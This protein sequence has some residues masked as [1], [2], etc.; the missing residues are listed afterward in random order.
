MV[1]GVKTGGRKGF[2]YCAIVLKQYCNL[3]GDA[4]GGGL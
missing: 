3:V 2:K 4:G 1:Y